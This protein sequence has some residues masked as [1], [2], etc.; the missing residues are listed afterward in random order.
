MMNHR[1]KLIQI[2]TLSEN[3]H[4]LQTIFSPEEQEFISIIADNYLQQK[5]VYT[6]TITLLIHKIIDPNQDIRLHQSNM[7]GGFSGRTIDTQYITLT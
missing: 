2:Y 3:I 1:D 7:K 4:D 6:V 5:A